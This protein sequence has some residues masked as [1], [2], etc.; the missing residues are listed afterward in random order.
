MKTVFYCLMVIWFGAAQANQSLTPPPYMPLSPNPA[1]TTELQRHLS[2]FTPL[3]DAEQF[4]PLQ[5][6]EVPQYQSKLHFEDIRA[7]DAKAYHPYNGLQTITG[8]F[9]VFLQSIEDTNTVKDRGRGRMKL[10]FATNAYNIPNI[11]HQSLMKDP[12]YHIAHFSVAQIRAKASAK[13]E[14]KTNTLIQSKSMIE[15]GQSKSTQGFQ[16]FG[17][18]TLYLPKSIKLGTKLTF[19]GA[20]HLLLATTTEQASGTFENNKTVITTNGI[21][22]SIERVKPKVYRYHVE[23]AIENILTLRAKTPDNRPLENNGQIIDF[24]EDGKAKEGTLIFANDI[25]EF[26]I[27]VAKSFECRTFDFEFSVIYSGPFQLGDNAIPAWQTFASDTLS[28]DNIGKVCNPEDNPKDYGP[29]QY[30]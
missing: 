13:I 11:Y 29:P 24:Q 23:G 25:G 8:P 9:G 22:L 7:F 16:L 19:K 30:F 18:D 6:F 10:T 14:K 5:G 2:F 21:K 17:W 20:I 26:E 28:A 15:Q 27:I 4:P 12:I 3:P 1:P